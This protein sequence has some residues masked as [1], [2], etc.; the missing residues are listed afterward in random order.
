MARCNNI[1]T[2]ENTRHGNTA[3]SETDGRDQAIT[4]EARTITETGTGNQNLDGVGGDSRDPSRE[5]GPA[6]R[7]SVS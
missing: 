6:T 3:K 7:R 5:R 2:E 1:S 4:K